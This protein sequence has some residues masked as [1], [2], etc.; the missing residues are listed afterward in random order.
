[1]QGA[2]RLHKQQR[3]TEQALRAKEEVHT[4]VLQ[5]LTDRMAGA[6]KTVQAVFQQSL[7]DTIVTHKEAL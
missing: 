4:T 5:A 3:N 2:E 7:Q 1:M 6:I